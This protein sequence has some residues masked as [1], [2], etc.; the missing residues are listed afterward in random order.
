MFEFELTGAE[1]SRQS[2]VSQR[3]ISEFKNGDREM[4]TDSLKKILDVMPEKARQ[5]Y[6]S[7]VSTCSK[8]S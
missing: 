6:F 5:Y 4:R 1:L 8:A 2:G 7:L 3:Q